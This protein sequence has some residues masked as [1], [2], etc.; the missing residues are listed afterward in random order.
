MK[1]IKVTKTIEEVTGYEANDG[2]WFKTA[3][4]CKKYEESARAVVSAQFRQLVVGG[5]FC[6][7]CIWEDYGFGNDEWEMCVIE[8]K[9][10]NDLEIAN[11]YYKMVNSPLIDK[12]YIGQR[13]LVHLGTPYDRQVNAVP[14]T[15]EQLIENFTKTIDRFFNL[16]K[17]D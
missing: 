7:T 8:I 17:E 9:D 4:E 6:E 15:R 5:V 14:R 1:E 12:S 16:E 13:V 2:T 3:E 10:V 11:R